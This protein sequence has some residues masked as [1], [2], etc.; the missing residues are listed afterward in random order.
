MAARLQD[1]ARRQRS[2]QP[3]GAAAE[4]T[5]LQASSQRRHPSHPTVAPAVLP[6]T[7]GHPGRVLQKLTCHPRP[8]FPQP[9]RSS[10][11]RS[12]LSLPHRICGGSH[13]LRVRRLST[14]RMRVVRGP[15]H[16]LRVSGRPSFLLRWVEGGLSLLLIVRAGLS[17]LQKVG[18]G[19]SLSPF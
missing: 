13:L 10:L 5:R 6:R 1:G 18:G 14:L 2:A 16:H 9:P 3:L 19:R 7:C 8:R 11:R 4:E 15:S 12:L 17:N